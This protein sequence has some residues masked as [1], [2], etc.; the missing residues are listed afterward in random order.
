MA[1]ITIN[2]YPLAGSIRGGLPS[3]LGSLERSERTERERGTEEERSHGIRCEGSPFYLPYFLPPSLSVTLPSFFLLARL[4][5]FSQPVLYLL[6]ID[7]S[8]SRAMHLRS[9]PP[10]RAPHRCELVPRFRFS[11]ASHL[12][13]TRK[14][15][16]E[17]VACGYSKKT[18]VS[19][20]FFA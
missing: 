11:A 7:A 18:C 17:T 20:L 14:S 8:Y 1:K 10:R 4:R 12:A 19:S 3:H 16:R 15:R 5:I 2:N 9:V 13:G 6:R